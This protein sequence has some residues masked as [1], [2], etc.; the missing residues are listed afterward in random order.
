VQVCTVAK[1][2]IFASSV[3]SLGWISP[4]VY[5]LLCVGHA[6]QAF[7]C[8]FLRGCSRP[9]GLDRALLQPP[10]LTWLTP[11]L[12]IQAQFSKIK[13]SFW[14]E[15][16]WLLFKFLNV[17]YRTVFFANSS[18]ISEYFVFQ[19]SCSY[20]T[21]GS[22]NCLFLKRL[23]RFNSMCILGP[24]NPIFHYYTW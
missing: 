22:R 15:A 17:P 23:L 4:Y 20:Y 12:E 11:R 1:R 9:N 2:L 19:L 5:M 6:I 8:S 14:R 13:L 21:L 24:L 3:R 10:S 7:I 16:I 18:R